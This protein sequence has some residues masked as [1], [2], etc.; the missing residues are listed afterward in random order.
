M[1]RQFCTNRWISDNPFQN[2]G[3]SGRIPG[4][5]HFFT[6]HIFALR[7]HFHTMRQEEKKYKS[8]ARTRYLILEAFLRLGQ[9]RDIDRIS[10]KSITGAAQISRSTF[11]EYFS[12]I[13]EIT[14][15]IVP[16][17]LQQMPTVQAGTAKGK[18]TPLS[19]EECREADWEKAWFR[20]YYR[21][22]DPLNLLLGVHGNRQFYG[23]LKNRLAAQIDT[24][25]GQDGFPEDNLRK[26]FRSIYGDTLIALAR[27]WTAQKNDDDMTPED[28]ALISS[29]LRAG[30]VY[31]S[32]TSD[33][34]S[35]RGE[36][37][38][39]A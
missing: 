18:I 23:K 9:T 13:N 11:Y 17:L 29:T 36:N 6:A 8:T 39:N 34:V 7:G 31:L 37:R 22:R 2:V 32:M 27:E 1:E 19:P 20:Y 12:D 4:G 24:R 28:L 15:H 26:Y 5:S 21:Y 30:G 14:A 33:R 35:S 3:N 16:F 10:V 25:M 38:R